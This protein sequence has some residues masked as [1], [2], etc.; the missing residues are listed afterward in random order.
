MGKNRKKHQYIFF[1]TGIKW[2]FIIVIVLFP[3]LLFNNK[4]NKNKL[5]N[6]KGR[7]FR[8]NYL[9]KKKEQKDD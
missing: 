9:E 8:V 2:T 3:L 7:N 6:R 1:Q 4:R 5:Y